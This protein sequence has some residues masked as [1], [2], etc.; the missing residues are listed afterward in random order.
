MAHRIIA[1]GMRM[2]K[3]AV[4]ILFGAAIASDFFL[5]VRSDPSALGSSEDGFG[6]IEATRSGIQTDSDTGPATVSSDSATSRESIDNTEPGL[7]EADRI[8]VRG[9]LERLVRSTAAAQPIARFN[10]SHMAMRANSIG[11]RFSLEN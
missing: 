10:S 9:E 7:A 3:T 4:T 2:W 11:R 1:G 8:P 5:F 6:T